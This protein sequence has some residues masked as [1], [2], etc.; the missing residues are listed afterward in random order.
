MNLRLAN[1]RFKVNAETLSNHLTQLRVALKE[2]HS[3][4]IS[5]QTQRLIDITNTPGIRVMEIGFNAGHSADVF[6][7]NNKNLTLV[8]FDIGEHGYVR[9]AKGYIDSAYPNRHTLI[10]GDSRVTVPNYIKANG[11][12]KFD[13]IFIDGGHDYQIAN[14]DVENCMKLA[15]KDTV[16]LLDDTVYTD[17]WEQ[18]H[19]VG[20][21]KVW[22]QYVDSGK[23]VE[24]GKEDYST[25]RG[26][27][28]GKYRL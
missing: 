22:T 7:K 8:S 18:G 10:L 28:W 24:L 2:G 1:G 11:D 25:G 14:S 16:V 6:L 26:M 27:S 20:P 5:K 4:D 15:H 23:I 3:Q 13:V 17:G 19:T 21:T 12:Q 9:I